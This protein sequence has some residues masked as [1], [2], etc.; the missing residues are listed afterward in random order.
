MGSDIAAQVASI[1]LDVAGPSL[2]PPADGWSWTLAD[3]GTQR[4]TGLAVRALLEG[5]W[6]LTVPQ[7]DALLDSHRHAMSRTLDHER[8]LVTI[9]QAFAAAGIVNVVLKG[10]AFAHPFYPDPSWRPFTDLDLLV[11]G[12]HWEH[13]CALL[14][15]L[16]YARGQPEPRAGFDVRFGKAAEHV[17]QTGVTVD[18]HRTLVLG[19]FGLWIDPDA[20]LARTVPLP[21]GA[22]EFHRLDDTGSLLHACL[23]ASLGWWPPTLLSLR[24]VAQIALLGDID[25]DRFLTWTDQ[26]RLHA[27]VVDAFRA[28]ARV[29]EVPPPVPVRAMLAA[30][31]SRREQR[32]IAC[33]RGAARYRGGPALATLAAIPG[34]R[35]KLAYVH[36]LLVPDR[37]FL[38]ARSGDGEASYGRRWSVPIRWLMRRR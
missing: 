17:D 13:A 5:S 8:A 28:V 1:G 15:E 32:L 25:W 29:L 36:A 37:R 16:G 24:D 12:D 11:P 7:A 2:S 30:P 31:V 20:L 18:L 26:W 14:E 38:A 22:R 34:L 35:A 4:L 27:V 10:P 3:L 9:G 19:P 33:Y 21:V 6:D 23:H